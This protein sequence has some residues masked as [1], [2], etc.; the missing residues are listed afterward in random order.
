MNSDTSSL[1]LLA[2][3]HW[4]LFP[5]YQRSVLL[6]NFRLKELVIENSY[7]LPIKQV[8]VNKPHPQKSG[9]TEETRLQGS[10]RILGLIMPICLPKSIPL[11]ERCGMS[12]T[13]FGNRYIGKNAHLLRKRHL[14]PQKD[15]IAIFFFL[16]STWIYQAI[17][18]LGVYDE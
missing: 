4:G 15:A 6:L 18:T 9:F 7:P 10:L 8:G 11:H 14:P 2:Q 1:N 16:V 13:P 17:K 5:A 12:F 3:S